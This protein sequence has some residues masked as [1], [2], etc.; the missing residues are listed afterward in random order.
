MTVFTPHFSAAEAAPRPLL[1]ARRAGRGR[2]WPDTAGTVAAILVAGVLAGC[3]ATPVAEQND[4]SADQANQVF[5]TGYESIAERFVDAVAIGNVAFAGLHG[6]ST[7]DPDLDVARQGDKVELTQGG[8]VK[9]DFQAP[10]DHDPDAWADLTVKALDLARSLSPKAQAASTEELYQAVFTKALPTLDEFSRYSGVETASLHRAAR[11]GFGGVGF[12][13]AT[14]PDGTLRITAILP[15]TPAAKGGLQI[16]DR[17]THVNGTEVIG[18]DV[19]RITHLLRGR[20]NTEVDLTVLR[21]GE[22]TP[23]SLAFE[24]DLIVPPTVSANREGDVGYVRITGFNQRTTA[25]VSRAVFDLKAEGPMKG[26]VLDLRNNPGGLLDQAIGVADL[27]LSDGEVL[28]TRGRHP[29][30]SQ[31]YEASGEDIIGGLPMV[32][33]MNGESASAAEVVAAA[34]QDRARAVLVGTVSYGKGTVQN[35]V[36]LPNDG[37]LTIT[38]SRI[39]SP[40]G[41]AFHRLGLMPGVCTSTEETPES[42]IADLRSGRIDPAAALSRWRMAHADSRHSPAELRAACPPRHDMPQNDIAVARDLLDDHDLFAKA[43][44]GPY[45]AVATR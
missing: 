7:I 9:A 10:D 41:Y 30:S 17:I 29:D 8:I 18:L 40:A 28:S 13:F 32:V 42:V 27:F 6:L 21:E 34:L 33:L 15:D 36:H 3:A 37:E 45:P 26:L 16:G 35:V 12:E 5:V 31:E 22:P 24:R 11:E 4:F 1:P 20:V 23:V 38:W 43:M 44:R 14:M 39:Y 2:R 19:P 25:N